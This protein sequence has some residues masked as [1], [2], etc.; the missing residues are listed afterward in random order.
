[1]LIKF[2]QKYDSKEELMMS[3]YITELLDGGWLNK[4]TYHP[5]SFVLSEKVEVPVFIRKKDFNEP[6]NIKILNEH[7]YTCDWE[8]EWNKKSEGIFYFLS[9][10]VYDNG[11]HPYSKPRKN[12]FVPFMAHAKEDSISSYIDVKGGFAGRNNTSG[13]TF[14]VNQKWTMKALDVYVQKVVITLDKKGLFYKTFFPRNVIISEVYKKDYKEFK[15]GDSKI[16]C[17]P[18]LIQHFIKWK[19]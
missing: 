6:K 10:G 4:A 17:E 18:Q 12:N 19:E 8:L 2:E 16:K 5:E 14:P 11:V 1:M 3:Y 7:K 9:G 13:I 15:A